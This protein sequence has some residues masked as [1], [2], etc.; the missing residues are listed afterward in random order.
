MHGT[1][2]RRV[3]EGYVLCS[4]ARKLESFLKRLLQYTIIAQIY[5]LHSAIYKLI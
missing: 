3:Q 2:R 4:F 1:A 5:H